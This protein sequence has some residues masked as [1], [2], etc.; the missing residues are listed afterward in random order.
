M[1]GKRG[2]NVEVQP[3]TPERWDDLV[4]LFGPER[5]AYG[6][7]WCMFFRH[8][9]R[10]FAEGARAGGA[11]NRSALKRI[12]DSGRVPGLLAY[13]DGR[14]VGWVSVAPREEF[15]RIER[16]PITKRVDD[17]PAWSIV[18]FY[19]HRRHRGSGV[20]TALL[21]A[22]VDHARASGARLVEAYPMDQAM[23]KI[24]NAGGFYGLLSMFERAGFQEMVRRSRRR[25]IVRRRLRPTGRRRTGT[26]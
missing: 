16:S 25:P 13:L 12:V 6:G 26:A 8:S 1:A 5:G 23:G 21:E 3:L 20:A 19:I 17:R 24:P 11:Q 18:C 10:A 4:E 7:C 2:V 22:A 9:A 15:G 14:P